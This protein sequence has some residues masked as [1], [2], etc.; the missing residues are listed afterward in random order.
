MDKVQ[1]SRLI[2]TFLDLVKI[3][4]PTGSEDKI[5]DFLIKYFLSKK[6]EATQYKNKNVFVKIPGEG[7]ALFISAHMDTVEPGKKINP[8]VSGNLI[9][10][11]GKTILGA[12][13]K[14]TLAIILEMLERLKE[15]GAKHR[16]LEI[17][18]TVDEESKGTGA[19]EFDYA[20]ITAK[21]GI[22]ADVAEPLGVI[23]LASPAYLHFDVDLI[24]ESGHAAYPETAQNVLDA[25]ADILK[26][27][28]GKFDDGTT[29]NIGLVSSGSARNTI[30]GNATINGEIRSYEQKI[31]EKHTKDTIH[32]IND[33]VNKHGIKVSISYDQDN[34][35]YVFE[36]GDSYIQQI[37][38]TFS[39]LGIEPKFIKTSSCSDA[40]VFNSKGLQ[41]VNIGD[42]AEN[43]HTTE[44][45]IKI[46]DMEK[47]LEIFTVYVMSLVQYSH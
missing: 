47:L 14:S 40:N 7:E 29:L 28:K 11:D 24:G 43:T 1:V 26:M 41:V 25:V 22:V 31:L 44:E 5:S 34:P 23:I 46:S 20:Q 12:D 35:G 42:G 2:S 36:E 37:A 38:Q 21:K 13:N 32:F 8:V 3:G 9:T 4:S 17:L 27:P 10:S 19:I 6:I 15:K 16:P 30:P 45:K 33:V 39:S 18:F